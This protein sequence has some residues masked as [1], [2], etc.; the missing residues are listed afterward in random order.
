MVPADVTL[1]MARLEQRK[2]SLEMTLQFKVN[3]LLRIIALFR[4]DFCLAYK[5]I[6]PPQ[7]SV[8]PK[9]IDPG[10]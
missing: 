10:S 3:T 1:G 5:L 6:F 7:D 2:L 9:E 4:I 8:F